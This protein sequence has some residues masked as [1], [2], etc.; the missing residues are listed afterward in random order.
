MKIAVISIL[1]LGFA[2]ASAGT[3]TS[4]E[5]NDWLVTSG[6]DYAK[7]PLVFGDDW[8]SGKKPAAGTTNYIAAGQSL[9]GPKKETLSGNPFTGDCF[10]LAGTMTMHSGNITWKD[11]RLQNGAVYSWA[12]SS[13]LNGNILVESTG[14]NPASIR[15]FFA[16]GIMAT[17][18]N[19]T[20]KG[21]ADSELILGRTSKGPPLTYVPD[22]HFYIKGDWSEFLGTV[23]VAT[24]AAISFNSTATAGN[25]TIGGRVV[26][27]RGGYWLGIFGYG[28]PSGVYTTVG[29]L[30]MKDGSQF[31]A[32]PDSGGRASLVVV[33]N[34]LIL[35]KVKLV[36]KA[37]WSASERTEAS[38][39]S[40]AVGSEVAIPLFKLTG[41][42]ATKVPDLSGCE[43]PDYPQKLGGMLPMKKELVCRNNADGSKTI[44]ARYY[45]DIDWTMNTSKTGQ[46]GWSECAL[47]PDNASYWVDGRMPSSDS[48]GLAYA[49]QPMEWRGSTGSV[50]FDFPDLTFILGKTLYF[51]AAYANIGNLILAGGN[52]IF[53]HQGSSTKHLRGKLTV[54]ANAKISTIYNYLGT[55]LY[56]DANIA[57]DGALQLRPDAN[58]NPRSY[59]HLTADNS[60]FHGRL[61]SIAK[62][63]NKDNS[64]YPDPAKNWY[65]TIY[66]GG[67]HCLGGEYTGSTPF[68]ALTLGAWTKLKIEPA[69][70]NVTLDEVNRGILISN[71]CLQVETLAGQKLSIKQQLTYNGNLLKLGEG[72]LELAG[73]VR[74][75]DGN[76]Q[77]EPKPDCN[78]LIVS[79]GTVTV[80]ATNAVDGVQ[81]EVAEDARLAVDAA[82]S[83][84]GMGE[85]GFVNTRWT[86]PFVSGLANGEIPVEVKGLEEGKA[87]SVAICTVSAETAENLKLRIIR[88]PRFACTPAKRVNAD[89][90]VTFSASFRPIGFGIVVR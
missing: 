34:E 70:N 48:A 86:T 12:S 87:A 38:L 60:E 76:S 53:V 37:I 43:I 40:Y 57:G 66:L 54:S 25:K 46:K 79:N 80:C 7:S 85:Y 36:Y 15:S 72:E 83:S 59:Y 67:D 32:R 88:A 58:L 75:I 64:L 33:T 29:S 14:E 3:T 23:T 22:H 6:T 65:T 11:L 19:A 28:F 63:E 51:Y 39:P 4:E 44:Y 17:D 13:A 73:P 18:M 62:F 16:K 78:R 9:K 55:T 47:N 50:G 89:G 26:V 69:L 1:S 2:L 27:E 30:E 20:V 84:E 8:Q 81:I 52:T 45:D 21:A 31:W 35:G 90:T 68:S 56:I 82:C 49:S 41:V 24:N 74:F 42:A 10:V 5:C 61:N 77:S 71:E